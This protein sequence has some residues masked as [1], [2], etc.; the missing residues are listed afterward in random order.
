[1]FDI[2][3]DRSKYTIVAKLHELHKLSDRAVFIV[4]IVESLRFLRISGPPRNNGTAPHGTST[5]PRSSKYS[6]NPRRSGR[7]SDRRRLYG[8]CLSE[9]EWNCRWGD[10]LHGSSPC[11]SRF[12]VLCK[13][14][15]TDSTRSLGDLREIDWLIANEID[16]QKDRWIRIEGI[17]F[18]KKLNT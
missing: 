2:Y 14:D 13:C 12:P 1:M 3:G 17:H 8:S 9:K 5:P 10:Q 18:C 11:I 16:L 7:V 6:Y 4:D 15:F